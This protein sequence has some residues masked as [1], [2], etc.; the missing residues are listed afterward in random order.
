MKKIHIFF[1]AIFLIIAG[2]FVCCFQN[3]EKY[4]KKSTIKLLNLI[5]PS[6]LSQPALFRKI[7]E[8]TKYVH[9]S[10]EYEVK[11]DQYFY[12]DR[13]LANLR[14]SLATYFSR[15]H[16]NWN[17]AIPSAKELNVKIFQSKENKTAEVA[18]PIKA[19]EGDKKLSCES[20]VH[21]IKEK[22]WLIQKVKVFSCS[23]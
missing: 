19:S 14:S 10:V 16:K 7:H 11:V 21:W 8:I 18:F 2:F 15:S 5:S 1:L 12:K 23:Y 9:F 20:L 22:K 4:L 6:A 3:D 17:I 13:S